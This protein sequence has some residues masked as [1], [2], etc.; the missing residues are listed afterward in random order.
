LRHQ[1]I[2]PLWRAPQCHEKKRGCR[3]FFYECHYVPYAPR[4]GGDARSKLYDGSRW[5]SRFRFA[6]SAC[7]L[8][9]APRGPAFQAKLCFELNMR[10]RVSRGCLCCVAGA[11]R[12]ARDRGCQCS[13]VWSAWANGKQYRARLHRAGHSCVVYDQMPKPVAD[14]RRWFDARVRFAGSCRKAQPPRAIWSCFRWRD[15]RGR[16]RHSER[17]TVRGDILIDGATHLQG[18]H[19]AR[20]DA[21][22][23]THCLSRCRHLRRHMGLER[24]YCM[25]IGGRRLSLIISIQFSRHWRRPRLYRADAR[26]KGGW[27]RRAGYIHAGRRAQA[28]CQ[29]DPQRNRVWPHAGLCGGFRYFARKA[30]LMCPKANASRS[31]SPILR[32][33]RRGSVVSSWLLDL[34]AMAFA[35]DPNLRVSRAP[36]RIRAKAVGPSTRR[37]R[38]PCQRMSLRIP[39]RAVSFTRG[40]QFWR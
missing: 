2:V 9:C 39:F 38:R 18:R 33:L 10:S 16:D 31:I 21:G 12:Q 34:S 20:E 36:S 35:E 40:T 37:S 11:E 27:P 30:D 6:T 23:Q 25:M 26:R 19:P 3:A 8:T 4:Y 13:W 24:G 1:A 5:A 14:L 15:N 32:G 28:F 7:S 17:S 22:S 29:D